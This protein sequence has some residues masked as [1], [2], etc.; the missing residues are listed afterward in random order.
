M[1]RGSLPSV[2]KNNRSISGPGNAMT[3]SHFKANDTKVRFCEFDQGEKKG[4]KHV[5]DVI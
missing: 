5:V 4:R 1:N 3:Y 2:E